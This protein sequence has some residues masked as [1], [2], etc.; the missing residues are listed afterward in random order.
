MKRLLIIVAG[1][2]LLIGAALLVVRI[3]APLVF[4]DAKRELRLALGLPKTW[5]RDF[6]LDTASAEKLACPDPEAIVIVTGGQSNAANAFADPL[7]ASAAGGTYM[8]LDGACYRLRDPVLGATGQ[9]G[10]LWTGLGSALHRATGRPVVFINGA[11]GGSQLGDW[12]DDRSGYRQR[13]VA[14]VQAARRAGLNPDT[15]IWIQ[16]ETDAAVLLDPALYVRQMQELVAHFD[17]EGAT[18]TATPWIV[19]RSTHCMQRRSNGPA[20]DKAI[21][22][23]AAQSDRIVLGPLASALDD[24]KRRDGCHFNGAGRDVLVADTL[25]IMAPAR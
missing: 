18:L 6:N 24:S 23:W 3:A 11:V 20:I 21:A 13:L 4:I 19:F 12:L 16:G 1:F 7:P 15:M 10:S 22:D 9:D 8:M 5:K 17:A 25:A 2:A 14:Q